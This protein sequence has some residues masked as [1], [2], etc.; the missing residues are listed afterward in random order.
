M[1]T[2]SKEQG[3]FPLRDG[4]GPFAIANSEGHFIPPEP[5]GETIQVPIPIK[6]FEYA[7]AISGVYTVEL[8]FAV[9]GNDQHARESREL[10]M[11]LLE[12]WFDARKVTWGIY[13]QLVNTYI[14]SKLYKERHADLNKDADRFLAKASPDWKPRVE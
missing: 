5:Q 12:L 1:V 11:I 13:M 10:L 2:A 4:Q 7:L 3:P 6:N 14:H 9:F 8:Q